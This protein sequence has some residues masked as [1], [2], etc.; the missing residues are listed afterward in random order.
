MPSIE[1]TTDR[2]ILVMLS[3]S[4]W[5][6]RKKLRPEGLHLSGGEIPAEDLVSLGSKRICNPDALKG[7]RRIKQS[8]ER[9]CL[10]VEAW[11]LGGFAVP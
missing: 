5:S 10:R 3:I 6:G 1:T 11:F 8:A 9:A 2:I 4:I 7:F